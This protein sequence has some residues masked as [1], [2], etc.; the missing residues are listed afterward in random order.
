VAGSKRRSRRKNINNE[1]YTQ[2]RLL[3]DYYYYYYCYYYPHHNTEHCYL[4][5]KR[6]LT[7]TMPN[8]TNGHILDL[9]EV[10][11]CRR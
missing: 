1:I 3:L 7:I 10:L 5:Y 6:K 11:L 4:L 2:D 9:L 8:Y